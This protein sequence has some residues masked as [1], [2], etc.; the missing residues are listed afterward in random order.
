M[1][2]ERELLGRLL[3]VDFIASQM[4][5]PIFNSKLPSGLTFSAGLQNSVGVVTR[6]SSGP[7]N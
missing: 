2:S 4:Q 7:L 3:S 6:T 5:L 1:D